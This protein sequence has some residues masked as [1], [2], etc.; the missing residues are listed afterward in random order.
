M[1]MKERMYLKV[2][3]GCGTG[4]C[5]LELA[6]NTTDIVYLRMRRGTSSDKNKDHKNKEYLETRTAFDF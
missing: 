1:T 3:I 2:S 4:T 5:T 6:Y